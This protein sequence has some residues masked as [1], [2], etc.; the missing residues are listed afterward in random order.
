MENTPRTQPDTR[1]FCEESI[2]P[3]QPRAIAN[4]TPGPEARAG[5]DTQ[6]SDI[7]DLLQS[8][9]GGW[10][11]LRAIADI[12]R[13]YNARIFELRGLGFQIKNRIR[14]VGG[15]RHSW[16]RLEPNPTAATTPQ[17]VD[18]RGPTTTAKVPL[19][20]DIFP[21]LSDLGRYPD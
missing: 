6:R 19:Q 4:R 13:Q 9:R 18:G 5:Y 3:S 11:P 17:A 1:T 20:G 12:A 14:E 2:N 21:Q 16:F 10:V 8:A 7:L 15:Q